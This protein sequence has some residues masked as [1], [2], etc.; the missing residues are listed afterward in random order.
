MD[1]GTRGGIPLIVRCFAKTNPR[2]CRDT[3]AIS[4]TS[5]NVLLG[6]RPA[7]GLSGVDVMVVVVHKLFRKIEPQ[8]D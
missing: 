1:L 6:G 4:E 2:L 3:K 8:E 7:V 5:V